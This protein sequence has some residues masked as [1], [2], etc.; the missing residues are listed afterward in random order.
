[1]AL[2]L[3]FLHPN[4]PGQFGQLAAALAARPDFEVLAI[5]HRGADGRMVPGVK[6]HYYD[7]FPWVE[8]SA[9]AGTEQFTQQV[10]RGRAAR[11]VLQDIKH[12]GFRPDIVIAHPGWGDAMFLHDIFPDARLISFMEFYYKRTGTDLDFDPEFPS[13]PSEVEFL[14]LRNLP[15]VMAY[16]VSAAAVSPT[17]WQANL[18]PPAIRSGI[19]VVHEGIDTSGIRPDPAA[20]LPL[21]SGRVLG[22]GDEVLTYVSRGLEPLRCFHSFMRALPEIQQRR[23]NAFTVIVGSDKAHYGKRPPVAASWREALLAELKGS[24]D[25]SRIWFAGRLPYADYLDVLR[26]SSVHAYLTYPFVLS[27]SL[28]EAMSAGCAIVGSRTAPVEEAILDEV[29]GV[30][31]D[32]LQPSDIAARIIALLSDQPRRRE[33]GRAARQHAEIHYDFQLIG[34]PGYLDLFDRVM[35]RCGPGIVE[36]LHVVGGE[37][38]TPGPSIAA[39]NH[40]ERRTENLE[41]DVGRTLE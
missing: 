18:F 35:K 28:L 7:A 12:D 22:R 37:S 23:P 1:M 8:H 21:P 20:R 27:W 14:R 10:R 40:R 4:F 16:E 38:S 29:T 30:L 34:L 26:V 6:V 5:G 25:L 39:E 15:S 33:L 3:L 2:R 13:D 9:F 41:A 36:P 17:H 11:Q 24:L 19:S 32:P 31:A